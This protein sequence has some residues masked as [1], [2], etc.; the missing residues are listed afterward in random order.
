V[1]YLFSSDYSP[2]YKRNVLDVLCYPEGHIFRFR[3]EADHV[4]KT[5]QDW[6]TCKSQLATKLKEVGNKGVTIYA[7]TA[8]TASGRTFNFYP[9]RDVEII[10]IQV[11]GSVYYL[12][13]KLGEFIDYDSE[14]TENKG[15]FQDTINKLQYRPL[16]PLISKQGTDNRQIKEGLTWYDGEDQPLAY[17]PAREKS[18]QGFFFF[19]IQEKDPSTALIKYT[20]GGLDNIR[21][22]ESVVK[23]LSSAPSMIACVFYLIE[24]F[25]KVRRRWLLFGK[26]EEYLISPKNNDWETK[27]PLKMGKSFVLKLLFYRSSEASSILPQTLE[28]KTDGDA[29][30]GFSQKE[31]QILSRYNEERILIACKRIFDSVFAPI[32][33]ELKKVEESTSGDQSKTITS[34]TADLGG[35]YQLFP[36]AGT[37]PAKFS[38]DLKITFEPTTKDNKPPAVKPDI[39]APNPFLLTQ[40][41]AAKG[42]IIL[43]LLLLMAASFFLFMSPDY[44]RQ[45]GNSHIAQ[46]YFKEFGDTLVRNDAAYT[47]FSKIIGGLCTLA[48]GFLAFRKLPVGK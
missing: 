13:L 42:L 40:I 1:F 33:I 2:R 17:D 25:Y 22:W 29:F 34:G 10:R 23:K 38:G 18:T 31:I 7:E 16:P 47:A 8:V 24:G 12:D 11:V 20:T 37:D 21:A 45:I 27:Y 48:A 39:L 44:I 30:A 15:P 43:T 6:G 3:Y 14:K 28:I 36:A 19:F 32:I 26:R 46:S 41:T 9:V 4:H 35:T 5:I